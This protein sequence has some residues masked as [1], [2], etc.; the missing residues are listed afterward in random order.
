MCKSIDPYI[1]KKKK[2]KKKKN[3]AI[4]DQSVVF[5]YQRSRLSVFIKKLF[6]PLLVYL[7]VDCLAVSVFFGLF[8]LQASVTVKNRGG[9]ISNDRMVALS[10]FGCW[11]FTRETANSEL[12]D[13]NNSHHFEHL[14]MENKI[15]QDCEAV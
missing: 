6:L 4:S 1:K 9:A 10:H 11:F 2:K 15:N 14:G 7:G 8:S 13:R 12:N 3:R 5:H